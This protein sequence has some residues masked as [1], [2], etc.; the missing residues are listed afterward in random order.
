MAKIVGIRASSFRG[1][2]GNL[3]E[4]YNVHLSSPFYAGAKNPGYGQQVERI[5]LT[6]TKLETLLMTY[7][8]PADLLGLE[9]ETVYNRWGKVANIVAIG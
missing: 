3:V 9:V 1:Q 2:D 4:G 7:G 8:S 6:A 5:F